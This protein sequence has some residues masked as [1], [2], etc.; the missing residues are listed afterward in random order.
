[1]SYD[2]D[3]ESVYMVE[4]DSGRIIHV[5]QYSVEDVKEYCA[6]NYPKEIIKTIYKEVYV[7]ALEEENE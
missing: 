3:F 4:F 7:A 2:S 5:G 6:D 1:M